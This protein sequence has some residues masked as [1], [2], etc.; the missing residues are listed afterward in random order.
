MGRI[1]A[2]YLINRLVTL[3]LTVW[4]AATLIWLIPRFSPVDPADIMLSHMAAGGGAVE[5]SEVILAQLQEKFGFTH[6]DVGSILAI[7]WFL[8]EDLTIAIRYHHAPSKDPFHKSLSSLIHLADHIA[9]SA[10]QPSTCGTVAPTLDHDVYDQVGLAP[11]RIEELLP[12]IDEDFA[13]G[14]TPW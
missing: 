8:P 7:K 14:G 12:Q 5:N 2:S 11:D 3:I 4:I 9:W 6:A 13:Q 1:P 10:G